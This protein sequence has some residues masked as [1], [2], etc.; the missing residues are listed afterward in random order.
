MRRRHAAPILLMA[1]AL[2]TLLAA[3]AA[4]GSEHP[5]VSIEYPPEGATVNGTVQLEGTASGSQENI[6]HVEVRI[7]DRAWEEATDTENWSY[8]W[9]TTALEDG[10]HTVAARAHDEAGNTSSVDLRNVTVQNE[11]AGPRIEI[12]NP[13]PGATVDGTVQI[14]GTASSPTGTLEHVQAR[15]DDGP[16]QPAQG[17]ETWTFEWDVGTHPPGP[18]NITV[19]ATENGGQSANATLPLHIASEEDTPQDAI[20]EATF[21]L[22]LDEPREGDTVVG[23]LDVAGR[24][25]GVKDETTSTRVTYSIDGGSWEM[26]EADGGEPFQEPVDVSDLD[27]GTYSFEAQA[28]HGDTTT[29]PV[30]RTFTVVE[31]SSPEPGSPVGLALLVVAILAAVGLVLWSRK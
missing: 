31:D 20:D 4:Q 6:T 18:V 19:R 25:E 14:E 7:D 2:L 11:E 3:P 21:A 10:E 17:L 15:I 8:P 1:A 13:L 26:F 28:V 5:A 23:T 29:E 27:P 24:V 30:E 16:W 12:D 22:Q 9:D